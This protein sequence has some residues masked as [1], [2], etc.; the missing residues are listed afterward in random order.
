M[1]PHTAAM[2]T[3]GLKKRGDQINI[4]TDILGKYVERF[5][6]SG[7]KKKESGVTQE[8]LIKHGFFA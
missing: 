6:N 7:Q 5:L 1:I 8:F 3:L 2:T 4:E